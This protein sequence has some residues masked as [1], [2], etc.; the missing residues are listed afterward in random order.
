VLLLVL[1]L[2]GVASVVVLLLRGVLLLRMVALLMVLV[3]LL[4]LE[5]VGSMVLLVGILR[6][7]MREAHLLLLMMAG[8]RVREGRDEAAEG[9]W[10]CRGEVERAQGNNKVKRDASV[11][12]VETMILSEA[13]GRSN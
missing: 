10:D 3:V 1:M 4:L 12:E 7:V 11:C 13:E 9:S 6:L 2:L 5:G 8:V